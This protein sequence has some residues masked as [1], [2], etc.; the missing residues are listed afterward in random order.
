MN[1]EGTQKNSP[2]I[3]PAGSLLVKEI[4]TSIIG[5]GTSAGR[6]GVIVRLTG[7]NLRCS[8][9]DTRYA[10]KGGDR[11]SLPDLIKKIEKHRQKRV[12]VT[13]GEPL[14]QEPVHKL[15]R[16]LINNGHQTMIETNGSLDIKPIPK[17]TMTIMDIKTPGSGYARHCMAENLER[18]KP[19][20][21]VKFVITDRKDYTF[22]RNVM[23]K[24]Q[25]PE[26]CTVILSSAHG[27][28]D[29]AL[30]AEWILKDR[31]D[32]LLGLQLHKYINVK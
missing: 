4:F 12:L 8:Y 25:L 2:G 7:C 10:Y 15:L 17:E 23:K 28:M 22:S 19:M 5:E 26:K 3:R 20:D 21:N 30:L 9:C 14:L 32:V 27:T 29:P 11:I 16:E 1:E 13:G 24:R 6:P 31:L 18:L